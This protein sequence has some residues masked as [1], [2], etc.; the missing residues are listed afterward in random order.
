MKMECEHYPGQ[1]NDPFWSSGGGESL[2]PPCFSGLCS[3]GFT[4]VLALCPGFAASANAL[5]RVI[6][7]ES[8]GGGR[9]GAGAS[10]EGSPTAPLR[11]PL[12]G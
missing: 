10:T 6:G 12:T 3:L 1:E 9:G 7:N 5:G 8:P 4:P 2:F 11:E